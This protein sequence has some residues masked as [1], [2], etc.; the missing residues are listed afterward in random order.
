MAE[1]QHLNW[2]LVF[3]HIWLIGELWPPKDKGNM[4]AFMGFINMYLYSVF[5]FCK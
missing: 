4:F 2:G 3:S 1:M 5:P